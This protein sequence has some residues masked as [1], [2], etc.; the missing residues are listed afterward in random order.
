MLVVG[1]TPSGMTGSP[2]SAL[3]TA[4]LPELNSPTIDQQEER[5]Q[6]RPRLAQQPRI[7]VRLVGVRQ[8]AG[9]RLGA[10]QQ[11]ERPGAQFFVAA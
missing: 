8:R 11:R 2:T 10:G 4:D 9:D 3:I 7:V 6:L 5:F 1:V